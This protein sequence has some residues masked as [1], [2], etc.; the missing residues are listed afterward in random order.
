MKIFNVFKTFS[1]KAR[2]LKN[3]LLFDSFSTPETVK[4][5]KELTPTEATIPRYNMMQETFQVTSIINYEDMRFSDSY[6]QTLFFSDEIII[7][8]PECCGPSVERVFFS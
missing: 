5:G 4:D 6:V 1:G 3:P 2:C 8:A 7:H